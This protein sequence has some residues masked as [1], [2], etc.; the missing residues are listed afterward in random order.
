MKNNIIKSRNSIPNKNSWNK[1]KNNQKRHGNN[2]EAESELVAGFL[3]EYSSIYFSLILLT[4]YASI[5]AMS[6]WMIILFSIV[7]WFLI[8]FLLFVSFLRSTLN[9]L[10]IDFASIKHWIT[11]YFFYL[12]FIILIDIVSSFCIVW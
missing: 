12:P 8:L 2:T 4:E 5:I 11:F 1:L 9:R 10:S 3:T 7:P 6:F